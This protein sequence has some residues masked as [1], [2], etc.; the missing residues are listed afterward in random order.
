MAGLGAA[1]VVAASVWL[2][3][4]EA[5]WWALAALAPAFAAASLS[6]RGADALAVVEETPESAAEH[7]STTFL[8]ASVFSAPAAALLF[9]LGRALA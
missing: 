8:L 1:L 9:G 6:A 4:S 5:S 3:A 7:F 2:G